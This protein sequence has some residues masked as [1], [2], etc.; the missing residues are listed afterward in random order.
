MRPSQYHYIKRIWTRNLG[1][2]GKQKRNPKSSGSTTKSFG[3]IILFAL[4]SPIIIPIAILVIPIYLIATWADNDNRTP[5]KNIPENYVDIILKLDK[6]KHLAEI[7]NHTSN[8]QEFETSLSELKDILN[9]LSHY[10]KYGIFKEQQPSQ[11]LK[12]IL[13]IEPEQRRLFY[14]REAEEVK[15]HNAEADNIA[16]VSAKVC[17][18]DHAKSG[19]QTKQK[20]SRI[21]EE[22]KHSGFDV[23]AFARMCNAY[24]E[25]Q[26]EL[27]QYKENRN[28]EED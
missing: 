19:E 5:P 2:R 14:L 26:D 7:V 27:E 17:V 12:N 16:P 3:L 4:F 22:K 25:H 20:N 6:S 8:R 1:R 13:D 24:L 10:E 9:E 23:D 28:L 11:A 21:S 15:K 18:D